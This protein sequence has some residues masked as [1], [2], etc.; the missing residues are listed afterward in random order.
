MQ[1]SK[2]STEKKMKYK[3]SCR[4]VPYA[5]YNDCK[6]TFCN[7]LKFYYFVDGQPELS[8]EKNMKQKS[9]DFDAQINP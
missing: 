9:Q 2:L 6:L 1:G 5:I 3:K 7:N 8:L 4:K